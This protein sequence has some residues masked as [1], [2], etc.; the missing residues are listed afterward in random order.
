MKE[1]ITD[2][3]NVDGFKLLNDWLVCTIKKPLKRVTFWAYLVIGVCIFGGSGFILSCIP[4][5]QGKPNQLISLCSFCTAITGASCLDIIFGKEHHNY[6]KSFFILKSFLLLFLIIL[7]LYFEQYWISCI[8][9]FI[10]LFL[11]W[12]VNADNSR[13]YDI[14]IPM[15]AVGGDTDREVQ[16]TIK[17]ISI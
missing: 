9:I 13:L 8:S 15:S 5:F 12:L 11:W 2:F 4:L 17:G 16:G 3:N 10:S 6:I 14:A 7:A 1:F